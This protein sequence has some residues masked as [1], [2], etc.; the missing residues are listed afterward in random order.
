MA[1][2][3]WDET[4]AIE[5][6]P[7]WDDTVEIAPPQAPKPP[8]APGYVESAANSV[9][10]VVSGGFLDELTGAIRSPMGAA[11]EIANKFGAGYD[12]PE[13]RN[14]RATRDM[15]R[16]LDREA[17]EANPLTSAA[18]TVAGSVATAPFAGAASLGKMIG[19]GAAQG[20][21]LSNEEGIGGIAQDAATGA[22]IGAASYGLAKGLP[23]AAEFAGNQS[24]ALANKIAPKPPGADWVL[25]GDAWVRMPPAPQAKAPE[26]S[27]ALSTAKDIALDFIPGGRIA[28]KLISPKTA[29][30]GTAAVFDKVGDL[31]KSAPERFGK[32]A[33]PLREAELRGPAALATT[34]FILQ[35][36][37]PEYRELMREIDNEK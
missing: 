5:A 33:G 31:L 25:E 17:Q 8:D 2:P 14:Y 19:L 34:Q 9:A 21:G 22:G 16:G 32:F 10:N 15:A 37:Q 29:Q 12:D 30:K 7:A 6:V 13:V 36:T 11:K 18:G 23:K 27:R 1:N 4:E 26:M 28:D 24:K 35:Q 3:T 20:L